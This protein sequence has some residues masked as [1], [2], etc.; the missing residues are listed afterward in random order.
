MRPNYSKALIIGAGTG[1]SASLARLFAAN[2]LGVSLAARNTAKLAALAAETGASIHACDSADR[3]QVVDLFVALDAWGAPDVVVYN[4][5]AR[6]RGP[7]TPSAGPGS[8][9]SCASAAWIRATSG[10][11]PP[12]RSGGGGTKAP[13]GASSDGV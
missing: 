7:I 4:P 11:A 5:S 13:S 1:L 8:Y 6:V 9:P 3:R 10:A 12:P 2:G